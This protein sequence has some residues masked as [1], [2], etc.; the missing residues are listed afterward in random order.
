MEETEFD[1]PNIVHPSMNG[2]DAVKIAFRRPYMSL[3]MHPV[4][5]PIGCTKN[6]QLAVEKH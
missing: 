4:N 1:R 6:A 3:I 5:A 2:M